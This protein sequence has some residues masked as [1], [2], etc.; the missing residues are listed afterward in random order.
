MDS[1]LILQ[2][3]FACVHMEYCKVSPIDTV[4]IHCSGFFALSGQQRASSG[5]GYLGYTG[6]QTQIL[7]CKRLVHV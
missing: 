2:V 1:V 5:I 7:Q 4:V 3:I 6:E